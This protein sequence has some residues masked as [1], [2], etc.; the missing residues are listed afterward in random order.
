M[1]PAVSSSFVFHA[2]ICFRVNKLS[3]QGSLNH[4]LGK[5]CPF[6]VDLTWNDV[7]KNDGLST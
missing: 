3:Q 4:S 5:N 1:T 7:F 2:Q 6:N